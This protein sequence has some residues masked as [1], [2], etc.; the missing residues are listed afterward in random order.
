MCGG[1]AWALLF[2]HAVA[3]TTHVVV[4][5]AG[6]Q[7]GTD[8]APG[9][10]GGGDEPGGD[11]TQDARHEN[12]PKPSAKQSGTPVTSQGTSHHDN[13]AAT[14]NVLAAALR[15]Q[16]HQP[17]VYE[18]LGMSAPP[19]SIP[20]CEVDNWMDSWRVVASSVPSQQAKLSKV[21]PQSSSLGSTCGSI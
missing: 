4:S 17:E 14:S 19:T 9:G 21:A 10:Q 8:S 7:P 15:H 1:A 5:V 20:I 11:G 3:S 6:A 16:L 2:V 18:A 13:A 12:S